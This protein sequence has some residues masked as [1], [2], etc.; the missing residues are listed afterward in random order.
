[1]ADAAARAKPLTKTELT[2]NIAAAA[3]LTPK[4]VSAVFEALN[5]E[6]SKSLDADGAGVITIPGLLK[7]EKKSVP[8]R[9][10]QIGVPN[11]FK[12][13]ELRD[14]AAKPASSKIKV[15]PLKQLK[16]MAK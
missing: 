11:P 4:Q 7:I 16:D 10:A 14:V 12:P 2:A 5:V 8:A 1:M 15:R 9:P 3:A 6:I 13:G